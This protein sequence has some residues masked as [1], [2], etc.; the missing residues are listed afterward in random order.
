MYPSA[1]T[2]TPRRV[3]PLPKRRRTG[4]ISTSVPSNTTNINLNHYSYPN[5]N[6]NNATHASAYH[7]LPP[8]LQ[9]LQSL[10]FPLPQNLAS[11]L[12]SMPNLHSLP[13][14]PLNLPPTPPIPSSLPIPD[15][16][17]TQW[18]DYCLPLLGSAADALLSAGGLGGQV[19]SGGRNGSGTVS[20]A[21]NTGNETSSPGGDGAAANSN[22]SPNGTDS[23]A[24]SDIP[25][26]TLPL[27]LPF[28][29][30]LHQLTPQL[31]SQ[32]TAQL[33]SYVSLASAAVAAQQEASTTNSASKSSQGRSQGQQPPQAPL[34][35]VAAATYLTQ[36]LNASLRA[37]GLAGHFP[38]TPAATPAPKSNAQRHSR[39]TAQSGRISS[40]NVD[41]ETDEEDSRSRVSV[42]VSVSE[43]E[44]DYDRDRGDYRGAGDRERDYREDELDDRDDDRG[45]GRNN[46]K[47]RKVPG[48]ASRSGSAVIVT[49]GNG[50]SL[51]VYGDGGVVG[52]SMANGAVGEDSES[53]VG[54][55]RGA[56]GEGKGDGNRVREI[57]YTGEMGRG[58]GYGGLGKAPSGIRKRPAMSRVTMAGIQHKTRKRQLANVLLRGVN[59]NGNGNPPNSI[60]NVPASESPAKSQPAVRDSS[61]GLVKPPHSTTS[62]STEIALDQ[63]LS[64]LTGLGLYSY[65]SLGSANN[66][67]APLN[68][69]PKVKV[70][71]SKRE[72]VRNARRPVD[73]ESRQNREGGVG[74]DM[75]G[76]G[77]SKA[78]K[79]NL[80]QTTSSTSGKK[81]KKRGGAA[82]RA[83]PAKD[84]AGEE[85]TGN[86]AVEQRILVPKGTFT[87]MCR[88]ASELI[89][90]SSSSSSPS[91]RFPFHLH[92]A[93]LWHRTRHRLHQYFLFLTY[94]FSS[95]STASD[96][97]LATKEEVKFLRN[98]FDA[99]LARQTAK[100]AGEAKAAKAAENA[101]DGRAGKK[102][103][104]SSA[105]VGAGNPSNTVTTT[106]TSTV[107]AAN[108]G[109]SQPSTPSKNASKKKKKK[110]SAL[111][112]ASNPHHLRNYVP[113]RVP[114]V[115]ANNAQGGNNPNASDANELGPPPSR[116]L[117]AQISSGKNGGKADSN[118]SV[119]SASNLINLNNPG[120]DWICAFCEYE[121]FYGDDAQF[122]KA[123]KKRK[124]ILKR[125]KR[126]REKAADKASGE[127]SRRV[128]ERQKELEKE[129]YN[130][131][132]TSQ[133]PQPQ[134]SQT[135]SNQH[136]PD[137]DPESEGYDEDD[138]EEEDGEGYEENAEQSG[139]ARV[140]YG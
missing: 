96:R 35:P 65:P 63:M 90:S 138:Y 92:V 109:A 34:D 37:A 19:Y 112:N 120:E 73:S 33:E 13:P 122:R 62:A 69:K 115:G 21:A 101:V 56:E 107:P 23:G 129:Q 48:L 16:L 135:Q 95:I 39:E 1:A 30:P 70:R 137:G 131:A 18:R 74:K 80:N 45:N 94:S 123:V 117:S 85:K 76:K 87:F 7:S 100:L 128:R 64:D 72:S 86:G 38:P 49:G 53:D 105:G 139:T 46:T 126:A 66:L 8:S 14:L 119:D 99:E 28:P 41:R 104:A 132:Q 82:A 11:S 51:N 3:K 140:A 12:H 84:A 89:L 6:T 43:V 58:Q 108:D 10:Q 31:T 102:R 29:L 26:I 42:S 27:P 75:G 134:S 127:A 71:L 57:E 97:L 111:A 32:L 103:I 20:G 2:N 52:A 54:G 68:E 25:G 17:L 61:K 88:N 121:L 5:S 44:E 113:S 60:S 50:G 9:S 91:Y 15:E 133:A 136:D 83:E 59:G 125:K 79:E 67:S 55:G 110:R 116:F 93:V 81:K 47:K 114:G 4:S 106:T 124:A 77:G 130:Q 98:R 78:N 118:T 24:I 36:H 22:P 40:A